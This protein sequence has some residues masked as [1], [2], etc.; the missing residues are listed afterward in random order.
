M[1]R[2]GSTDR[3]SWS[4]DAF[5]PLAFC[6]QALVLDGLTVPP[7]DRHPDGDGVLRLAGL[8][9]QAWREW[10]EAV[11]RQRSAVSAAAGGFGSDGDLEEA[12]RS[13]RE[14]GA[15]LQAIG[16][17]CPGS[18]ELQRQLTELW[19][20]YQPLGD[21][22]KRR[23]TMGDNGFRQRL[24][25]SEAGR[26][27]KALVPF[28]DRLPTISVFLVDYPVP[29]VMTLPPSTCLIAPDHGPGTYGRQVIDAATQLCD[30]P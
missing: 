21:A 29:A 4:E 18:P 27:W 30:M 1:F 7:F 12:F 5:E 25:P 17:L 22:W 2:S 20:A 14:A 3:W 15:A 13:A 6:V 8:D 11:V 26:L 23:T 16:S 24:G 28:H 9:A 10:V 19:V